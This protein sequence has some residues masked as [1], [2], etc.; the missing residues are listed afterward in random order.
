[1][2]RL[3][4]LFEVLLTVGFEP[5]QFCL[6][7]FNTSYLTMRAFAFVFE[8]QLFECFSSFQYFFLIFE[9]THFLLWNSRTAPFL[10]FL[11]SRCGQT[12]V[13][14]NSSSLELWMFA[15]FGTSLRFYF[16]FWSSVRISLVR[17]MR[18]PA[19]NPHQ[20]S[21]LSICPSKGFSH[22]S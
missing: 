5:R 17:Q 4:N 11:T 21:P 14:T 1:M 7:L 9:M 6:S 16:Y 8:I 15:M 2:E 3:S 12:E 10:G 18:L 20:P 22:P 13:R 19:S